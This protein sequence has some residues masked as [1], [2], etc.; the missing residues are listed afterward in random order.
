MVLL[1]GGSPSQ[2]STLWAADSSPRGRAKGAVRLTALCQVRDAGRS[3]VFSRAYSVLFFETIGDAVRPCLSLWE[4]WHFARRND[5]E[6]EPSIG[7]ALP[8]THP[9]QPVTHLTEGA[10]PAL[11]KKIGWRGFASRVKS[12]F[13]FLFSRKKE[14]TPVKILSS[15]NQVLH[16]L[17]SLSA[18]WASSRAWSWV[19]VLWSAMR[20]RT[21]R[22]RSRARRGL[23]SGE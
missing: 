5:G 10:K 1:W 15:Q 9:L 23:L 4:R 16:P 21:A 13:R 6:G 7:D 20:R 14:Q 3:T 11:C 17:Y 19:R 8:G 22:V 18:C 12:F 2:S